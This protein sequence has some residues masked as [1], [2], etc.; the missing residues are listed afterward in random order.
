M[1][2]PKVGFIVYGV[3]K[4]GLED[5]MG[6]PFIDDAIVEQSKRALT[7]AGLDLV[8]HDLVIATKPEAVACLSKYKAMED[9]DGI[10]LFS[11][12]WVWAS[13][14]IGAVRDYAG[15][16]KGIVL[17]THPGSQGWRPVGGLV[18]QVSLKEVVIADVKA[19]CVAGVLDGCRVDLETGHVKV[20]A[21]QVEEKTVGIEGPVA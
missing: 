18:R 5:P 17:W 11:G 20:D 8:T 16:R 21:R 19:Q 12:T 3:H 15:S 6:T 2:K 9:L 10:V 7:D 13:N 14:L 1:N 4:D